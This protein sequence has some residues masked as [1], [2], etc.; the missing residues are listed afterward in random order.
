[1][2]QRARGNG[3][4]GFPRSRNFGTAAT[5]YREKLTW[6]WSR[7]SV[8]RLGLS[9]VLALALW[10]YISTKQDPNVVQDFGQPL[11]ISVANRPDGMTVVNST[12]GYVYVRIRREDPNTPV[13]VS[14]F[15]PYVNLLGLSAGLHHVR[16]HV[17]HDPGI[18]VVS[19]RPATVPVMLQK[20]AKQRV[21]VKSHI[22]SQP[23]EGFG[24]Q[25]IVQPGAVTAA[26]P[27]HQVSQVAHASFDLDLGGLRSTLSGTYKILPENAS[28][29]LVTGHVTLSPSQVHVTVKIR[30][31]SSYKTLP[32]LV[33]L[34]GQPKTGYGV[35]SVTV[36]PTEITATGSPGQLSKIST[37]NTAPISLSHRGPGTYSRR[38]KL[39]L[40]GGI[41]SRT[42]FVTVKTRITAVESS[43]SIEVAV[44]PV[45]VS[46]G[47]TVQTNPSRVLV[48]V[49]GSANGVHNAAGK[50]RATVNLNGY[51]PGTY[52]FTPSVTVSS[53]LKVERVYPS[54]VSVTL[55]Q[56]AAG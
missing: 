7:E 23:P 28:G 4:R 11:S 22:L 35:S 48:T 31:L 44:S 56:S 1:M 41:H 42:H 47:L 43:N 50:M 51:G 10:L 12:L 2:A 49:V 54:S 18:Q 21:S 15:R 52:T 37:V 46:P 55:T 17:D 16:V 38:V 25:I 9:F 3:V 39:R 29:G 26:G 5:S 32:V 14:S 30:P 19:W 13:T 53:A 8:L 27:P 24:T 36:S 45:G 34:S 33:P 20:I 40:P 6:L